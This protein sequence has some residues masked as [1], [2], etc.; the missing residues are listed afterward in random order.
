MDSLPKMYEQDS[1]LPIAHYSYSCCANLTLGNYLN[2]TSHLVASSSN[3]TLERAQNPSYLSKVVGV[4]LV[5][6]WQIYLHVASLHL[7][8]HSFWKEVI[9]AE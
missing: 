4:Q 3:P 1:V 9:S 5:W 6:M 7:N 8:A 2:Y